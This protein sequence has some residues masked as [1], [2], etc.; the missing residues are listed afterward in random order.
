MKKA[1]A[2]IILSTALGA[3]AQSVVPMP[4]SYTET[5]GNYRPGKKTAVY[6]DAAC[7][8][9]TAIALDWLG[10]VLPAPHPVDKAGK[11]SVKIRPVKDLTGNPEGYRLDITPKSI[12]LEADTRTG[13]IYG[14]QTLR[15]LGADGTLECSR[16][17]DKP[18]YAW[19][20]YL[21]DESR[22]F[23]GE[24]A[25]KKMIDQ[26]SR[27]K[28]NT[29]HW[30]LTDGAG[31]RLKVPGYPSL[32]EIGAKLD[33][34]HRFVTPEQWDSIYPGRKAYYDEQEIRRIVDYA[35]RRGV[36][37]VPEIEMPGHSLAA[38]AS[39]N[40][41]GSS[42]PAEGKPVTGDLLNPTSPKVIT[43]LTD[44]LDY[45]V[46]V[47]KP[48]YIHIGGDE[49]D[50]SHWAKNDSIKAYLEA[51]GMK[52][53]W[54][55]QYEL[56]HRMARYLADKGVKTI[57]WNEITGHY[58]SKPT[59]TEGLVA[60]FWEGNPSKIGQAAKLGYKVVNSNQLYTY[61]DY[62]YESIPLWKSYRHLP[63]PNDLDPALADKVIGIGAQ[64]WNEN[65]PDFKRLCYQTFPRLAGIAESGWTP[66][67]HRSYSSFLERIK[68]LQATWRAEGL[69]HEQ[70]VYSPD[71][72]N[73]VVPEGRQT[74]PNEFPGEN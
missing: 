62:T 17:I 72:P 13:L 45:V 29:L 63:V 43:F 31:W 56:V 30:H 74:P 46:D 54:E 70:P 1:L 50:Y 58:S 10:E 73:A 16:T 7:G 12:T 20:S 60:Q 6:F 51:H 18:A 14:L 38:I 52:Q 3:S 41:L 67:Q 37:V 64:M 57:G 33:Y 69:L 61:L 4:E 36:K 68:P 65:V 23:F 40:W 48:E 25:V 49:C 11:A 8:I 5:A 39:Y 44:V 59:S 19:R 9:D 34:T 71:E 55:L 53:P 28:I 26:L 15:Q 24:E 27:L 42:T 32:T 47:F 2:A 35:D 22:H 21:L 66:V